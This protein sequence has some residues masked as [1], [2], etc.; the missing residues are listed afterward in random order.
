MY[1]YMYIYIY[2]LFNLFCTALDYENVVE[3]NSFV[4]PLSWD[5]EDNGAIEVTYLLYIYI[6][7]IYFYIYIHMYIYIYVY[8]HIYVYIYIY[9]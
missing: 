3:S 9:I 6:Y 4:E 8:I 1:I 2:K 7:I 5:S